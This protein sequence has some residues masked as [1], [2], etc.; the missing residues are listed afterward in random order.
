MDS[1]LAKVCWIEYERKVKCSKMPMI[2]QSNDIFKVEAFSESIISAMSVDSKT[3]KLYFFK[4]DIDETKFFEHNFISNETKVIE[5]FEK[6]RPKKLQC[7]Y[8]KCFW[9]AENEEKLAQY[10]VIGKSVSYF[11]IPK[12]VV[13]YKVY[14]TNEKSEK[15]VQVIPTNP[16]EINFL[17]NKFLVQWHH[18]KKTSNITYDIH[19]KIL[20]EDI[21]YRVSN[22]FSDTFNEFILLCSSKLT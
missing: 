19:I 1:Y 17:Q 8:S 12:N 13:D 10:D 2:E 21:I 15:S 22:N 4:I 11:K 5:T 20:S 7:L 16:S 18:E 14:V 6:F 3:H 9:L